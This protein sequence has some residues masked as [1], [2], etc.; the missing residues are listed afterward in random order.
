MTGLVGGTENINDMQISDIPVKEVL[1]QYQPGI[2][3][4]SF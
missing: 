1:Q 4:C 2:G 3:Q